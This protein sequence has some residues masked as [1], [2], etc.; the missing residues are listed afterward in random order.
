MNTNWLRRIKHPTRNIPNVSSNHSQR[1][2]LIEKRNKLWELGLP[3]QVD[4]DH[5]VDIPTI[6]AIGG[7]KGG[8]GKSLLSSNLSAALGKMG[9]KVL[10][11]DM[12]LGSA[13]LHT[14]F[15]LSTPK[16]SLSD[17]LFKETLPFSQVIT[18]TPANGVTMITGGR[19]ELWSDSTELENQPFVNLWNAILSSKS[20]LSYDFVLLDLGAGTQRHT[21]DFFAGAHLGITTV[22]PEPTS[23]ENAY[24]F[25]KVTY[26]RIIDNC[27]SLSGLEKEATELKAKLF[28][29]S[30]SKKPVSFVKKMKQLYAD[31]SNLINIICKSLQGRQIGFVVNQ[32]RSQKDIEIATSMQSITRNFFGYNTTALGYLN[33]D[34]A[35]WKSLRNQ[36]L[37]Y[38]DFPHSILSKRITEVSNK[39]LT[40]LG[41]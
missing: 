23:I 10:I 39:A 13:N 9:Y 38:L 14:Y 19:D 15:G 25:L 4:I 41:Y 26:C 27:A 33:Y 29:P 37:L 34:E 32:I 11:V 36:R 8:V 2:S 12:D 6:I 35:A 28:S 30:S 22:L 5:H 1:S 21:I 16:T 24:S 31:Y 17:F 18:K 20:K 7:G 3:P 40:S